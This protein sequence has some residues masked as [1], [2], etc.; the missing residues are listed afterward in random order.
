MVTG[1]IFATGGIGFGPEIDRGGWG[2][3]EGT[4]SDSRVTA[5]ERTGRFAFRTASGARVWGVAYPD[6]IAAG[7]LVRVMS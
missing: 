7:E 4:G 2:A 1:N 3:G 6:K 5:R